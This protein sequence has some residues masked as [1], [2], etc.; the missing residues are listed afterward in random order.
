[1]I[2]RRMMS[3]GRAIVRGNLFR[4]RFAPVYGGVYIL[5]MITKETWKLSSVMNDIF[6]YELVEKQG[7]LAQ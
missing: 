7:G 4:Q 6:T 2:K 1:M 3:V 5:D